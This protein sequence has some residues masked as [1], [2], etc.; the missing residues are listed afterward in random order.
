VTSVI[1]GASSVD[2]LEQNV[3][4]ARAAPVTQAEL[5]GIEPYA[6]HGTAAR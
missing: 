2:Q 6:V 1:I 4:A 5:A 3:Q